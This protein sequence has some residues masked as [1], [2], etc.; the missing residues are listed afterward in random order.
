[1][2]TG[3][4]GVQGKAGLA[5]DNMFRYGLNCDPCVFFNKNEPGTHIDIAIASAGEFD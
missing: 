1:M 4:E 3:K 2:I 5:V